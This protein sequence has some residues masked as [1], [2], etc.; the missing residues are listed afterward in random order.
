[1]GGRPNQEIGL[2]LPFAGSIIV[3]IPIIVQIPPLKK[4]Y[5]TVCQCFLSGRPNQEL[6]LP[7]PFAGFIIGT[8]SYYCKNSATKEH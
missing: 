7:I 1:L 2:R 5:I 3:T 6:G 8:S 4:K